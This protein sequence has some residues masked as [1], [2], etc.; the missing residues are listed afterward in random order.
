L[1]THED[2]AKEGLFTE[3]YTAILVVPRDPVNNPN[4][5][6]LKFKDRP[7]VNSVRSMERHL[8][9]IIEG[10][11]MQAVNLDKETFESIRTDV[12]ILQTKLKE[13][14]ASEEVGNEPY[15]V[16]IFSSVLIYFFIFLYGSQVLRGVIE[17]KTNRIVEIIIS[18]VKPFQLMLGKIVGIAL[19]GL[20]QFAIWIV[21]S[22]TVITI[23]GTLIVSSTMDTAAI[24]EAMNAAQEGPMKA[25]DLSGMENMLGM[26]R[27]INFPLM[28][29]A[30]VF[31]FLGGYLLYS[32]LFAAIGAMVDNEADTQQFMLPVTIPLIFS[33]AI[34]Q[35]VVKNPSGIWG[36]IFSIF[37]LT[38][39]IVMMVRI[40]FGVQIWELVLS[41]V[42]LVGTFLGTTWMAGRI[43]KTGILL[44]GKKTTYKDL[45]LWLRNK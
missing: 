45:W 10:L 21:L 14:G 5:F 27:N 18:S 44:Y 24:G 3:R 34:A 32:S 16:G 39:P 25:N 13:D 31:Y 19:V 4:A 38:S 29:S 36:Q 20:T 28:I 1:D 22:F 41:V 8:S 30:F 35:F 17:E 23:I 7:G 42:V 37:P 6:Q 9:H 15:V 2:K 40:P 43:Y 26:L 33:I 12:R 11:K